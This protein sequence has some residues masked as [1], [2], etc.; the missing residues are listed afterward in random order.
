MPTD[1]G[2]DSPGMDLVP[3]RFDRVVDT[4]TDGALLRTGR[5]ARGWSTGSPATRPIVRPGVPGRA[6][7]STFD[8]MFLHRT[9]IDETMTRPRYAIE[10]WSSAADRTTRAA[11]SPGRAEPASA[12]GDGGPA[13]AQLESEAVQLE[14]YRTGRPR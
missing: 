5:S 6:M 11:R 2:V 9:A 1:C 10:S 8:D 7:P 4:G 3:K 13:F 14:A 12:V